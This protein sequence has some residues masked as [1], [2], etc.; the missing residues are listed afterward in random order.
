MKDP[1][2]LPTSGVICE[3]GIISRVLLSDQKDP[4]NREQLSIEDCVDVPELKEAIQEFIAERKG[5]R[6]AQKLEPEEPSSLDF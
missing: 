1:V 3:R 5:Q 2:K 4:F 6:N